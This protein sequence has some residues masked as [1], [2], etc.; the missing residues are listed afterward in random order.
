MFSKPFGKKTFQTPLLA[1][2][3]LRFFTSPPKSPRLPHCLKPLG[4]ACVPHGQFPALS[5]RFNLTAFSCSGQIHLCDS[6]VHVTSCLPVSAEC[7][8][9]ASAVT[10]LGFRWNS[11]A[12]PVKHSLT[13]SFFKLGP[14]ATLGRCFMGTFLGAIRRYEEEVK[15]RPGARGCSLRHAQT[16]HT[17]RSPCVADFLGDLCMFPHSTQPFSWSVNESFH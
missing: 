14:S 13:S 5:L 2:V 8:S 15:S 4:I 6:S 3:F 7:P 12:F 10:L 16:A 11:G 9:C 1:R 17:G